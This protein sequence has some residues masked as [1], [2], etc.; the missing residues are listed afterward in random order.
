M[1]GKLEKGS[2]W[3]VASLRVRGKPL[4]DKSIALRAGP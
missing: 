4:C 1:E 2:L 3:M